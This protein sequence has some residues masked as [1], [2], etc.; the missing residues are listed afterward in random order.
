MLQVYNS[1]SRKKEEFVPIQENKVSMYVCGMTVYDF[2]HVGHARVLVVFDVIYRHLMSLGYDV[3]YI[4]NITDIDD[5]IIQRA[6]ENG[7]SINELTERFIDAMHE[8]SDRLSVLSPT[9]EPKATDN[10]DAIISMTETL[11]SKGHAYAADNGDVYYSVSSFEGYGK[12]S[13]KKLEDLQAGA[14]V[15]VDEVKRDPLDF[16][17]WKSAKAGEPSW[18]SPWGEGRPGW[19]IECSAMSTKQLGPQFDIHGGGQDL[20]F[21]HHE[22]EIAQSEACTGHKY[23]NYWIHNGFVRI[24]EEKMSKSL[25]NFFTVRDVLEHIKPETLR[26]FIL[27]SHYRSPLNYS[28]DNLQSAD[29]ALNRFYTALNDVTAAEVSADFGKKYR[30]AFAK[31]MNDD[32]NTPIALSVLFELVTELNKLKSS[33]PQEVS[34]LAGLLLELSSGLGLLREDPTAFLQ[35]GVSGDTDG[36]SNEAIEQLIVDR[37]NAK[38]DKNWAESDRIR[39]ELKAQ[40][41]VLEDSAGGTTWRRDNAIKV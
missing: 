1:L 36:L 21:P 18:S 27:A 26:Y 24:N 31:A 11:I 40:G 7:E 6:A 13:G 23:V 30:D 10:L 34:Q 38:K 12:L 9:F 14:R 32:F 16:V 17:L 2:C 4:R 8:D 25:G 41:I 37:D 39:D 28:E 3:T 35:G 29:A 5:K 19:H 15:D 20:Q 22:N 33:N